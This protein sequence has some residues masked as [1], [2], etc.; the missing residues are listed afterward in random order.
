MAYK[1]VFDILVGLRQGDKLSLLLYNRSLTIPYKLPVMYTST[2][3]VKK[4]KSHF[5]S[6]NLP[7]DQ[8]NVFSTYRYNMP[9]GKTS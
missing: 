7:V 3:R 8:V 1:N 5:N 4:L 2:Q 9:K 6:A